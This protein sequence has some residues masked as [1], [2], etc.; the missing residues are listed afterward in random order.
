MLMGDDQQPR[1]V[2]GVARGSIKRDV[3]HW[4]QHHQQQQ[5][6]DATNALA[7]GSIA[8]ASPS[9]KPSMYRVVSHDPARSSFGCN[10]DHILVLR[11]TNHPSKVQRRSS[12]DGK[13]GQADDNSWCFHVLEVHGGQDMSTAS[14]PNAQRGGL[15]VEASPSFATAAEAEVARQSLL[16]KWQPLIW[17]CT[18]DD[19]LQ[20]SSSIRHSGALQMYQPSLVQFSPPVLSLRQRLSAILGREVAE[21]LVR[22]T[23]WM[24]GSSLTPGN[25]ASV[26]EG[27]ASWSAA[28]G[29]ADVRHDLLESYGMAQS[30]AVPLELIRESQENRLSLLAGLLDGA[31]A[32]NAQTNLF[33]L[34]SSARVLL[35]G[36]IHL[37][38]SLGFTTGV[39]S[40]AVGGWSITIG[41]VDLSH[42]PTMSA[43]KRAKASGCAASASARDPRASGFSIEACP[44]EDAYYG[45]SLDANERCLLIDF[46]VTHNS[47]Y[48]IYQHVMV[49]KKLPPIPTDVPLHPRLIQ[50]IDACHAFEPAARPAFPDVLRVLREVSDELEAEELQRTGSQ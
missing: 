50:L 28:V 36:A 2:L 22:Q 13:D 41:G 3:R 21:D 6:A 35:G 49:D 16:A 26:A 37:C 34:L 15:L 47:K 31:G 29:G 39:V 38:R 48:A 1:R 45:L 18:V 42:I 4:E 19:Y 9:P 24:L 11:V 20:L 27:L 14:E 17:E 12:T 5:Q 40:K 10:G 30:Q 43:E 33:S 25:D 7:H 23:A 8:S 32:Y 46:V 44:G